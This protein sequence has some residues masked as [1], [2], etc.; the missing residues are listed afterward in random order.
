MP[1]DGLETYISDTSYNPKQLLSLGR[2]SFVI[3]WR[4]RFVSED[5]YTLQRPLRYK[6]KWNLVS[7]LNDRWDID[8]ADVSNITADN[9]GVKYLLI[10][11]DI[12]TLYL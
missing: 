5:V 9:D 7:G 6:F 2:I 10:V 3:L 1:V 11:I 12:F 4:K 8:S